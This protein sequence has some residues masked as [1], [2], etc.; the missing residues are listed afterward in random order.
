MGLYLT[1]ETETGILLTSFYIF[2]LFRGSGEVSED[3]ARGGWLLR[4]VK[5]AA[6]NNP[7]TYWYSALQT[8]INLTIF[9]FNKI[10]NTSRL[11]PT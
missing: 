11:F 5:G 3:R 8:V 1:K 10:G 9:D 7:V 4:R 2:R 6:L